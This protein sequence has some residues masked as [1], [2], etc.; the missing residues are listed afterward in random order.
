VEVRRGSI[1]EASAGAWLS[2]PILLGLGLFSGALAVAYEVLWTRELLNLLGS[3]TRASALVLAGFMG[4]L[5]FGAYAAG[6]WTVRIGVPLRLFAAAEAA[7]GCVG[8]VFPIILHRVTSGVGVGSALDMTLLAL[9]AG[10]AFLMGIALP[11]LAA[12]LQQQGRVR[13]TYVA[14][15]YGLSTLGG[16]VAAFVVGLMALP[17]LGLATSTRAAAAA[18]LLLAAFAW[19]VSTGARPPVT[20][21][22]E[23]SST[24]ALDITPG[25]STRIVLPIALLLSG[26][27]ALGYEVLWTRILVLVVGS[28]STAF[29]LMLGFYL[30]GLALGGFVTSRF[31]GWEAR[32]AQTFRLLQVAIAATALLGAGIFRWLPSAAL[33][34]YA[35]LGTTPA[36]VLAVNTLLIAAIILPPTVCIGASFPVA[37]RLLQRGRP[38][39]G[40]EVGLALSLTTAGNV[41]GI[42]IAAFAIIPAVGLQR[43]VAAL[44]I[45]NAAVALIWF[46]AR[47]RRAGPGLAVPAAALGVMVAAAASPPWDVAVMTSGVFRQAPVYLTLLGG[48]RRLERAF[49]A[50]ETRYYRE[51]TEAVVAVFDRPALDGALHRVL[52]I[53][54]KVDASTG[55]DMATQ[56]LSG[57]LPFLVRPEA[58]EALVIGLASG[59]TVGALAKHPVD[60]IDVV[61]IEPAVFD[62]SRAFDGVSGAPLADPRVRVTIADGRRYLAETRSRFDIIVSEPSNPWLSMSARLFTR[63]FF[64]LARERLTPDG[65]LVQWVPLYGLS[66]SQFRALLRTLLDVFPEIAIFG[67]AEGDLVALAGTRPL[68]PEREGL[69]GMFASDASR[70][71]RSIGVERPADVLALWTADGRALR[72][73]LEV[74]PM[75]TDDNGLLELGSPWYLL[76]DTKSENQ[77]LIARAESASLAPGRIARVLL[78]LPDGPETLDAVAQRYLERGRT[79]ML[80]ALADALRSVGREDLAD[81]YTGDALAAEGRWSEAEAPW[82]RHEGPPFRLR[83]ARASFNKRDAEAAARLFA[84]TPE[85][86]RSAQ[87]DIAFALA[88]GETGRPEEALRI[89]AARASPPNTVSAVVEPFVRFALSSGMGR[90]ELARTELERFERALDGLRR[91]LEAEGCEH[92]V[93]GLLHWAEA[94]VA[95]LEARHWEMLRQSVFVRITRPL[96]HYFL[97]VRRLWLGDR[98]PAAKAFR[99]YLMLLPEPDP[100]SMAHMLPAAGLS[101]G[102]KKSSRPWQEVPPRQTYDE[103]ERR[104]TAGSSAGSSFSLKE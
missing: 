41:A 50:Y 95:G 26:V 7:L 88:L 40:R 29:A 16:A 86:E 80:R 91:C 81:L 43:G 17:G 64:A 68:G 58:K 37:A 103:S 24:V 99:T 56:V 100:R 9:L 60:G 70:Q 4:G 63:E 31:A 39:R 65:V 30:L 54:G 90:P 82:A 85:A 72:E 75:N 74:G 62:A 78:P 34:G 5:A 94:G 69:L 92:V 33:F 83:L 23:A 66:A 25:S 101:W 11:S 57:H 38:R 67:V 48:A 76:A 1:P 93:E 14:A 19:V 36:G 35:Q 47:R 89:L 28:S 10:P 55:A 46:A 53:D 13:P 18:G 102:R 3:A 45:L 84:E 20:R 44:V 87:D 22:P 73:A 104:S 51:G 49:S 15:L 27:A 52:T 77:A 21:A 8:L 6:R 12:A 96:P 59:V 71:L 32:P 98:E 42:L 61:E 79:A 2:L 97:A